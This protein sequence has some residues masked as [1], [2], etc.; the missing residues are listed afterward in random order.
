M[1]DHEIKEFIFKM[2]NVYPK[3]IKCATQADMGSK[4]ILWK[5]AL[6]E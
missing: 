3:Y 5:K 1:S 2:H 6:E 4:E